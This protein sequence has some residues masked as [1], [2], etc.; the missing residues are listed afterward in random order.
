M[1]GDDQDAK[2][3]A[4]E[5]AD[6]ITRAEQLTQARCRALG[7]GGADC[8]ARERQQAL[9]GTRGRQAHRP[10]VSREVRVLGLKGI[11]EL[12]EGDDLAALADG[13]AAGGLLRPGT[14]S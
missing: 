12:R 5:L 13:T 10:A 8:G 7:A 11:P 2:A 14:S 3:V 1:C 9:Q 6:R 4:L